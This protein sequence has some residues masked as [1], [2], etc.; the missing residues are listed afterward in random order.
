VLQTALLLLATILG[1]GESPAPTITANR[2]PAVKQCRP[3]VWSVLLSVAWAYATKSPTSVSNS[4]PCPD[5]AQEA[6]Q[7]PLKQEASPPPPPRPSRLTELPAAEAL[8]EARWLFIHPRSH[9]F[10][11]E[12]LER[13]LI[14]RKEFGEMGLE[15]TR[16]I[17]HA[18]LVL[19]ITRKKITSRF[20]CA[21]IEPTTE[22]VL[23][24]VTSSS[25]GGEIEPHLA[26]AIVKQFKAARDKPSNGEEKPD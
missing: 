2:P 7:D 10:S 9:W 20:T 4:R 22:R 8:R 1:A 25:L 5:D 16:N 26:E 13:E 14:K 18:E 24:A 21:I 6:R 15:L 3:D 23:A 12:K 17:N 19:E 11:R